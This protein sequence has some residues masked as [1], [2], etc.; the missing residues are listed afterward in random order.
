MASEK[1][2]WMKSA[3]ATGQRSGVR[4]GR[5]S[6]WKKCSVLRMRTVESKRRHGVNWVTAKRN[7]GLTS[8]ERSASR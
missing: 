7:C 5:S 8:D 6:S 4:R 3:A 1:W 2:D